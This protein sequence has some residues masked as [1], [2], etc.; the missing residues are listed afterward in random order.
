MQRCERVLPKEPEQFCGRW[1]E[2]FPERNQ[3]WLEVGCGK[4]LFS[5]QTAR[6]NPEALLVAIEKVPE[7]LVVAMERAC[8]EDLSNLLFIDGDATGLPELFAEGE[9]DRIFINFCDPWRRKGNAKRRLTSPAFLKIYGSLLRP[10]GQ[11]R[12]K[13]DNVPLFDYS[14]ETLEAEG[15]SVTELTRDLHKNGAAEI[16]TDYE[17]KFHEQGVP[18]CAL[19]AEMR[20]RV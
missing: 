8:A 6:E 13:T 15:W 9:V 18:I 2:A 20:A 11:I 4:G 17:T 10:G 1:L 16:M 7:A 3:L 12:F 5:A 14:L 19:T